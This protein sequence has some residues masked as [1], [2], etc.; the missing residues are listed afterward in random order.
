MD[1]LERGTLDQKD[2]KTIRCGNVEKTLR[3]WL[4]VETKRETVKSR[5]RQISIGPK[6]EKGTAEEFPLNATNPYQ[7]HSLRGHREGGKRGDNFKSPEP[8]MRHQHTGRREVIRRRGRTGKR[9]P[10]GRCFKVVTRRWPT[11]EYD[12]T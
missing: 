8:K 1:V 5:G 11:E 12:P 2:H 3:T 9:W 7:A 10:G 6:R 4:W